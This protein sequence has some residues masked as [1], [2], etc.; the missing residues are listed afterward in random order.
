MIHILFDI[1]VR[2]PK[3]VV[4]ACYFKRKLK[5]MGGAGVDGQKV[6]SI[7]Q[8]SGCSKSSVACPKMGAL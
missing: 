3:G 7:K 2:T 5:E 8:V 6:M 1:A 4:F